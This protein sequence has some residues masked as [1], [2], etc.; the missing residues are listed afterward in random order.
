MRKLAITCAL[1]FAASPALADPETTL[2]LRDGT[3]FEGHVLRMERGQRVILRLD[4]DGTVR[5][6]PWEKIQDISGVAARELPTVDEWEPPARPLPQPGWVPLTVESDGDSVNV[7]PGLARPGSQLGRRVWMQNMCATPCTYYV[8]PGSVRVQTA[9]GERELKLDVPPD[10]LDVKI[11]PAST[12]SSMFGMTLWMLG[13]PLVL[14]SAIFMP[15]HGDLKIGAVM[16]GI[17]TP[18]TAAGIALGVL[19]RPRVISQRRHI[20]LL[21]FGV[22]PERGGAVALTQGRF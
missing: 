8:L 6:V 17:G 13:G 9:Y 11:H 7:G 12:G 22:A 3:T 5:I 2:L 4:E 21:S 10:G 14:A 15:R 19:A 20:P 18:M 1:L 16:L